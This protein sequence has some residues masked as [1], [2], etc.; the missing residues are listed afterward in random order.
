[1]HALA[2]WRDVVDCAEEDGLLDKSSLTHVRA[3]LDAPDEWSK[4]HGEKAG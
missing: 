2:T 4:A 3:F 1:L